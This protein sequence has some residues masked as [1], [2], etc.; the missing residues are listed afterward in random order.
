[1]MSMLMPTRSNRLFNNM[2][3]DPF[4]AFFDTTPSMQKTTPS[5]MRTDIR[6]TESGFELTVDLPGFSK[7]D[8]S[9]ELKDGYLTINAQTATESEDKDEKGTWIRKER[10]SG[11]CSR[12]FYVGEDI[13]EDDIRAKFEQG[14]LK[15]VVPK[16]QPQPKLEEKRL[17]AIEG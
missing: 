10:F 16:K 15:I 6:E 13:R 3:L 4:D 1:M 7:D 5:L 12:S 2:M 8:V 9:A 14:L 17:I 11:S